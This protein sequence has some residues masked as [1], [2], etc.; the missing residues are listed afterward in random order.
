[1]TIMLGL[2][3]VELI[4]PTLINDLPR[5]LRPSYLLSTLRDAFI[6]ARSPLRDYFYRFTPTAGQRLW[7]R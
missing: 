2:L 4:H 5:E 3:G 7:G 1:M 6:N